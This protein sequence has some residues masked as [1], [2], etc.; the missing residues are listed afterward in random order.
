MN[1]L[2]PAAKSWILITVFVVM[3]LLVTLFC[4]DARSDQVDTLE[5]HL[6][7]AF[8]LPR[9]SDMKLV[10]FDG[11]GNNEILA[12]FHSDTSHAGI[13]D[14]EN[15]IMPWQSP[16]LP[17]MV[18]SVGAG[19]R[20]PDGFSDIIVGGRIGEGWGGAGFFQIIDGP[21]LDSAFTFVGIEH[22]VTAVGISG[23][24]GTGES[25]VLAGTEYVA[26][27]HLPGWR[28]LGDLYRYDGTS[29]S[30][31]DSTTTN[32]VRMITS[33]DLNHDQITE[34]VSVE[35]SWYHWSLTSVNFLSVSFWMR[36]IYPESTSLFE[37]FNISQWF[38]MPDFIWWYLYFG[39]LE[40]S[41]FDKDGNVDIVVG[42]RAS[43]RHDPPS[44][45]TEWS[46]WGRLGCFDATTWEK[47][48][49]EIDSVSG[50]YVTGLAACYPTENHDH[51][52]CA[53][54]HSGF[55]KLKD[56]TN[57]V[58]L[59]VSNTLPLINH[60]A[61][62]NLDQDNLIELCI[63]S[64]ESLYVYETPCVTTDVEEPEDPSRP[65]DFHLCQN[66]PNPFN[67]E[68]TIRYRIP[69]RA[70]V[71][72]EIFNILG[73][74]VKSFKRYCMP[75]TY[76]ITWDGKNSTGDEVASGIYLYRLTAGDIKDTRKMVLL[77]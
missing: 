74:R 9:V 67:P 11:D 42:H 63:A 64:D 24:E 73:E 75:G 12:G 58:D 33:F 1:R 43:R 7:W 49:E 4:E 32:A 62:G 18:T 30:L 28:L 44:G 38:D 31:K 3:L 53:A 35:E 60:F 36:A 5:L 41:D 45:G 54:Y 26:P 69:V 48:W 27:T 23:Q 70:R 72:L 22:A 29:L 51:A 34:L 39:A 61:L 2:G 14:V 68:T 55:I 40:L 65:V 20:Q 37:F 50:D 19:D 16:G 6:Q 21:D 15:H 46:Y 52:I 8:P 76:S 13:L 71:C 17:G 56:A 10:D 66:Y 25:E 59:A 47:K 77:R 57:G